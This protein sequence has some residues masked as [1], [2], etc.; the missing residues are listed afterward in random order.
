MTTPTPP[1]EVWIIHRTTYHYN[2]E[3]Y[4]RGEKP[5]E[6][7]LTKDEAL[8]AAGYQNLYSLIDHERI[9]PPAGSELA[10]EFEYEPDSWLDDMDLSEA[11]VRLGSMPL[12]EA[13]MFFANRDNFDEVSG[14]EPPTFYEAVKLDLSVSGS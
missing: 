9:I 7:F 11:A 10:E 4:I 12:K 8:E 1:S 14:D 6:F 2:D 3:Y 5:T 13:C